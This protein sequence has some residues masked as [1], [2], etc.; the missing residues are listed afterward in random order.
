MHPNTAKVLA[1]MEVERSVQ[2]VA[3]EMELT[4]QDVW[5]RV[6]RF[7]PHLLGPRYIKRSARARYQAQQ[8]QM[9]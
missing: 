9:A 2:A 1:L 5:W 6:K 8:E 7:A 3:N 4:Q